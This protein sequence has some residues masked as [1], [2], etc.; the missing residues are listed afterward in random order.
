MRRPE[1][2]RNDEIAAEAA[3]AAD[4]LTRDMSRLIDAAHGDQTAEGDLTNTFQRIIDAETPDVISSG[5]SLFPTQKTPAEIR[6]Q[7][8]EDKRLEA[9]G[10]EGQM[11]QAVSALMRSYGIQ[12]PSTKQEDPELFKLHQDL[13]EHLRVEKEQT[14]VSSPFIADDKLE[15]HLFNTANAYIRTSF[16][17]D[18]EDA[19][20]EAQREAVSTE[21][22]ASDALENW[23]FQ[24]GIDLDTISDVHRGILVRGISSNGGVEGLEPALMNAI[25]GEKG[26]KAQFETDQLLGTAGTRPGAGGTAGGG[27]L[28]ESIFQGLQDLR[29]LPRDASDELIATFG[30]QVVPGMEPFIVRFLQRNPSSNV[31]DAIRGVFREGLVITPAGEVR[32]LEAE[33]DDEAAVA[34]AQPDPITGEVIER[35]VPPVTPRPIDELAPARAAERIQEEHDLGDERHLEARTLAREQTE[36]PARLAF[37]LPGLG[38][39]VSEQRRTETSTDFVRARAERDSRLPKAALPTVHKAEREGRM[40]DLTSEIRRLGEEFEL[41][42]AGFA[43]KEAKRLRSLRGSRSRFSV[44]RL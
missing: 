18:L 6:E 30:D 24:N 4:T 42:P 35:E 34:Q 1:L 33:R 12:V 38:E 39:F 3:A 8:T 44:V 2:A 37:T 26:F 22:G 41:S 23:A 21:K 14:L 36:S 10:R 31:Q 27:N 5:Q 43:E 7:Q 19:R 40:A 16:Q 13:I 20:N 15:G 9:F 17:P 29:F 25:F 28:Q 11:P 32:Q